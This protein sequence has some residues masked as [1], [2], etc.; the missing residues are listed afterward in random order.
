MFSALPFLVPGTL[1]TYRPA[2]SSGPS[3]SLPPT[4]KIL[5]CSD[6][7]L[8]VAPKQ[9]PSFS[10]SQR[11]KAMPA[12][13]AMNLTSSGDSTP[14]CHVFSPSNLGGQFW[15]WDGLR[16]VSDRPAFLFSLSYTCFPGKGKEQAFHFLSFLP[17]LTCLL[18]AYLSEWKVDKMS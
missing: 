9:I 5:Q 14:I 15:P 16:L 18:L 17:E 1:G 4:V 12:M 6:M 2:Y 11:L 10:Q 13:K 7:R 3:V 8:E